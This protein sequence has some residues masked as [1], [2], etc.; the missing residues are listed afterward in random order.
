MRSII[1]V[2]LMGLAMGVNAQL[3]MSLVGQ[4][5]YQDLH[6]SDISDVWGYVDETGIEY[7][8]VGFNGGGVSVV[9]L[10][11]PA[12]PQ[13]VFWFP[14]ENTIWRD[15]KVWNDHVYVTNEGGGGL[16]II[17]L[18]PLPQSTDLEARNWDGGGWTSAHNIYI[19]EFGIA[20]ISGAN[21]GNGGIIFLDLTGDPFEPVEVGTFDQWYSHDCM[22]RG[23]TMYSAHIYEGIFS[24]VDV[25]D[26][27]APVLLGTQA[28]GNNFAHN[29]WVSDDGN[30]LYTTDEV[31]GGWLGSY[32]ISDPTDIQ[33]LQLFRSD[34][35]SNTIP[36]NTHFIN[37]YLV[38]S[39][40]RLGTTIHDVSRPANVVEVGRYD[41][42]PLQGNGFNGG[43][44]TYPWLPS[45]RIISTDIEGGLFVLE[46][47]YVRACWLEGT[48]RNASTSAPV[49][50]ATLQIVGA[51]TADATGFD[52][53]YATGYHTAGTY[54]VSVTAPGYEPATVEGVVLENG[55]VTELDVELVPLV[56]FDLS[57]R[58][59]DALTGQPLEG[60]QVVLENADFTLEGTSDMNGDVVFQG[61]FEGTY[62]V[63]AGTWG[64]V[65][66]CDTRAVDGSNSQVVIELERGYTDDFALDLGWS[67]STTAALGAWERGAPA[68]TT[69]NG[70]ASNPGADA[71][72][73]CGDQ[74]Y[75]TGNAGGGAGADD[76]DDGNTILTSPVFDLTDVW[77]PHVRYHR[78]FFNAGGSGNPNDRMVISLEN[79][80]ESVELEEITASG[81]GSA[82]SAREFRVEDF[83]A[84]TSTMRFTVFITDDAPGH[85]V[86]GGLDRF[87]VVSLS[88]VG[89][90]EVTPT[91]RFA[92]YPNPNTGDFQLDMQRVE[93]GLAEM[94]DATG[95]RVAGPWRVMNGVNAMAVDLPVGTYLLSVVD[96]A[97]NREVQRL[98]ITR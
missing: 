57:V 55:V 21:R 41:H 95:R 8:L 29:C 65:T 84:P 14:G 88:P 66:L 54:Q 40:Y 61:S 94:L 70:Q 64:W 59:F 79:G 2:A 7:A 5:S 23:D 18:G 73:D 37:E 19:D 20:Y 38:T 81:S 13:E 74:A 68:G 90:T 53:A 49:P 36:H 60:A 82:W 58:V 17:D 43:W 24:I 9:S 27:S 97:G 87:E 91:G 51:V 77:D 96:I 52:G 56:P 72:G 92:L 25:S 31:T 10:A 71:P 4:L 98:V 50:Q 69:F 93:E 12:D 47:T 89:V 1:G 11:D 83:I 3:N 6:D 33:E 16:A 67:V 80:S 86:E 28:T 48:I 34:P 39:Y 15:L 44:G 42:S 45:G 63:L 76:V 46:P 26:K 30:Y 32:D 85:L 62:A 78:W 35:G 22:A 75:V